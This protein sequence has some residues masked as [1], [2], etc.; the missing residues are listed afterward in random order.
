M[1][2][3]LHSRTLFTLYTVLSNTSPYTN[4]FALLL[5]LRDPKAASQG[6]DLSRFVPSVPPPSPALVGP[7]LTP[8]LPS[9]SPPGASPP[10]PPYPPKQAK[11]AAIEMLRTHGQTGQN[12][13]RSVV[14]LGGAAEM[15]RALQQSLEAHQVLT[16]PPLN[17]SINVVEP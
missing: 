4:A 17:S 11:S 14:G 10:Y 16:P 15:Q 7:D 13:L 6:L 2:N 9:C 1:K 8:L 3:G 12:A 5:C